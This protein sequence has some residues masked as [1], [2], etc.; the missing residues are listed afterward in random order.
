VPLTSDAARLLALVRE[1]FR[2]RGDR[3][4]LFGAQAVVAHG[5][6]RTTGDVDVTV[7]PADGDPR[8]LA[9]ALVSA[10]LK[11]RVSDPD[12]FIERTA[13][14]PFLHEASGL[15]LDVVLGASGL[16]NDCIDRAVAVDI[17]DGTVPVIRVE[18][19]VVLKILS[20][21]PKDVEDVRSILRRRRRTLDLAHIRSLLAQ[22]EEALGQSDLLPEL[23]RL[24][25]EEERSRGVRGP[26]DPPQG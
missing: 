14:I 9:A 6:P 11:L 7:V 21:R 12:D 22:L 26:K 2:K 13:V 19:L 15:G 20:G 4:F 16:E 5:F 25:S 23:E 17:G 24:L 1:V 10:G 18:D 8:A 3:W